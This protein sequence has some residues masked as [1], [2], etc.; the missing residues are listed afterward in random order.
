MFP[1]KKGA[2]STHSAIDKHVHAR[3]RRVLSQ[4]FGDTAV[5]GYEEHILDNITNFLARLD[6]SVTKEW[7][8]PLD[9]SDLCNYLTFDI[10]GDLC[11]GKAFGMLEREENRFAIELIGSAAKRHLIVSIRTLAAKSITC[12]PLPQFLIR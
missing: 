12:T 2:E 11:F 6:K 3:K 9:M 5:K 8:T 1:A 4:A 10:M 7:G